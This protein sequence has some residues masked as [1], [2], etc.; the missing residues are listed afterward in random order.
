MVSGRHVAAQVVGQPHRLEAQKKLA[1]QVA[2]SLDGVAPADV[3]RPIAL[4]RDRG[5]RPPAERLDQTG[6]FAVK[7]LETIVRQLERAHLRDRA[8]RMIQRVEHGGMDVGQVARQEKGEVLATAVAK[9]LVCT[10]PTREDELDAAGTFPLPDQFTASGERRAFE[11][12]HSARDG[13]PF[14]VGVQFIAGLG[15]EL[16][17]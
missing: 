2:Q 7:R 6:V 16:G 11:A 14:A 12:G 9:H 3:D 17:G 15:L 13:P 5:H 1:E 10:G 4:N 8:D